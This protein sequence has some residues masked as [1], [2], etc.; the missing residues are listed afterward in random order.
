MCEVTV[1]G[2]TSASFALLELTFILFINLIYKCIITLFSLGLA[3]K[4]LAN[5]SYYDLFY[6]HIIISREQFQA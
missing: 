4:A 5:I 3:H 2:I 1:K 6:S